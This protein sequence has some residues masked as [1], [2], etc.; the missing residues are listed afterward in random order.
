MQ[1]AKTENQQTELW[2]FLTPIQEI[3]IQKVNTE[4]QQTELWKPFL[5]PIQEVAIQRPAKTENLL[6]IYFVTAATS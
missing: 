3:A 1:K 5:S 2:Q 6:E 4:N